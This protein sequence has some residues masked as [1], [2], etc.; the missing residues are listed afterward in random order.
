MGIVYVAIGGA[1]G[2]LARYLTVGFAARAFGAGFPYG[3]MIVNVAGSFIMGLAA[4]ILLRAF[5]SD[6]SQSLKLFIMTGVLGGFT[7][8]SAF[9]LEAAALIEDERVLAAAAYIIGSVALS[10]LGLFSGLLLARG[11]FG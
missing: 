1:I 6:A 10:I 4:V 9:S 8:F 3:T 5:E 7:T 11:V 2:A